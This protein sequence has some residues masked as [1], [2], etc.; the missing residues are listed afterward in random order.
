MKV[1]FIYKCITL[2]GFFVFIVVLVVFHL[3]SILW[4]FLRGSAR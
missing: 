3:P 1:E 4:G 2:L